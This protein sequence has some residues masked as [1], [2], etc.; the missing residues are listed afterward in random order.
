MVTPKYREI[1]SDKPEMKEMEVQTSLLLN[2]PQSGAKFRQQYAEN[3]RTLG[4]QITE[5][6]NLFD[7]DE[8]VEPIANVLITRILEQSRMEV[9]EEEEMRLMKEQRRQYEQIKNAELVEV[10][11]L[12]ENE[13]R[14]E[15]EMV[16]IPKN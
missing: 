14:L 12:E 9:L 16:K 13:K 11:R 3:T 4:T 6:D 5:E 10:Q 8:E 7:F 2:R 15:E 1:L